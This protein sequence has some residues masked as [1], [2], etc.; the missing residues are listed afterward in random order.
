MYFKLLLLFVALCSLLLIFGIMSHLLYGAMAM[1]F[2]C[3]GFFC[4]FCLDGGDET[5][6]AHMLILGI[7]MLLVLFVF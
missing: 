2:L 4:L 1:L 5:L 7:A 6:A 3:A